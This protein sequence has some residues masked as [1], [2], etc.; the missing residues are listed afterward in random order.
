MGMT[1]TAVDGEPP[2][3]FTDSIAHISFLDVELRLM[4]SQPG[5]VQYHVNLPVSS[6][7]QGYAFDAFST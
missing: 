4:D 1:G 2:E 5:H 6:D 7:T 3:S